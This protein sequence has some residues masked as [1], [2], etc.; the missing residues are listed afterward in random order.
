MSDDHEPRPLAPG[1]VRDASPGGGDAHPTLMGPHDATSQEHLDNH[2]R[3]M[4]RPPLIPQEIYDR[5]MNDPMRTKANITALPAS[6]AKADEKLLSSGVHSDAKVIANGKVYQVHKSI[7]CT[8]SKWFRAAL[9]GGFCEGNDSIVNI[10]DPEDNIDRLL[11]FIY[12]GAVDL[13]ECEETEVMA[14]ANE[15]AALGDFYQVDQMNKYAEQILGHYLETSNAINWDDGA[16]ELPRQYW[17]PDT[18]RLCKDFNTCKANYRLIKQA[19]FVDRLCEA[20]RGAYAKRSGIQHVYV[21]FVC[22]AR[23]VT[24]TCALI[25]ELRLELPEFG[26]DLLTA[27]MDGLKCPALAGNPVFSRW[28]NTIYVEPG[29]PTL[30]TKAINQIREVRRSHERHELLNLRGLRELREHRELRE[31]RELRE[32]REHRGQQ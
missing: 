7:L 30:S 20:I 3:D 22:A 5:L 14:A 12:T 1:F 23:P 11:E 10:S 18:L 28:S 8:R 17:T 25:R 9:E 15:I 13:K 21:A 19:G 29:K 27:M 26:E 16:S 31:Q 4:T 32:H 24:F 6:F 2:H